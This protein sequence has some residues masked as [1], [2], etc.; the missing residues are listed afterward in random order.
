[1]CQIENIYCVTLGELPLRFKKGRSGAL[2]RA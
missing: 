2:P 1:M